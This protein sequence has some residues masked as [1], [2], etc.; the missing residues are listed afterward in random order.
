MAV[1]EQLFFDLSLNYNLR[2]PKSRRPTIIYAVF[3]ISGKQYKINI[4]A[5][6]YPNQWDSRLQMPIMHNISN[7]DVCNNNVVLSQINQTKLAF[8]KAKSYICNNPHELEY[9]KRCLE[10]I[11]Q[12]FNLKPYTMKNR[13]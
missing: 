5:K 11:K 6:V 7:L 13:D 8:D 4:G 3:R 12:N 2:N 1:L 10:I 9:P